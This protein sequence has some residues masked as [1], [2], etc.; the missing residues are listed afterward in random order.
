MIIHI[1]I[2]VFAILVIEITRL[3]KLF[4]RFQNTLKVTKKIIKIILSKTISD[5]WREKVILKYSQILLIS[6]LQIFGILFLILIFF[7]AFNY[8]NTSFS[9]YFLSIKGIV[10][11]TLIILIYLYL[12][13]FIY[14]KL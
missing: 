8:L 10:E 9:S 7:Y 11:T 12:K 5:H 4:S 6:S 3:L 2:I 13:K 14:A 1:Q